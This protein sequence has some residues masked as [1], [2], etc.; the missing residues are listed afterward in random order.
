MTD[1]AIHN[2]QDKSK[3]GARP[4]KRFLAKGYCLH[5]LRR[6]ERKPGLARE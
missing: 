4:R 3:A 6:V 2:E 5:T 1:H